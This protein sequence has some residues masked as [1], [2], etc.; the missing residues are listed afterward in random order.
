MLGFRT[1]AS[2][3]K[4]TAIYR[5][6]VNASVCL[7][8]KDRNSGGNR[9]RDIWRRGKKNQKETQIQIC[10]LE[11]EGTRRKEKRQ[12]QAKVE[13]GEEERR[14]EGGDIT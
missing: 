3:Y 14:E 1:G 9:D 2:G 10:Q 8:G 4:E 7:S 12:R 11:A 5:V 13:G 6:L